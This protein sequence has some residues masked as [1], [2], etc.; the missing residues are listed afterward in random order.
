MQN[1]PVYTASD[2]CRRHLVP[3]VLPPRVLAFG[4]K[5]AGTAGK[6]PRRAECVDALLSCEK[7]SMISSYV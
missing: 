5:G 7:Q 6:R 4:S 3:P 1:V 2:V